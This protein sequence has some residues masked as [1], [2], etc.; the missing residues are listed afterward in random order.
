MCVL[1][2]RPRLLRQG[3]AFRQGLPPRLSLF[4]P[5]LSVSIK[6]CTV[7]FTVNASEDSGLYG[8]CDSLMLKMFNSAKPE[9]HPLTVAFDGNVPLADKTPFVHPLYYILKQFQIY[10]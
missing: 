6:L 10:L 5:A 3:H 4:Y 8:V 2:H 9:G 7:L 1:T